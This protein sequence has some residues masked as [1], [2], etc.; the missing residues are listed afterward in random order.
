MT[1][2]QSAIKDIIAFSLGRQ[3][4]LGGIKFDAPDDTFD[5]QP[6]VALLPVS[7]LSPV[8]TLTAICTAHMTDSNKDIIVGLLANACCERLEQFIY[9]VEKFRFHLD[10]Y[11]ILCVFF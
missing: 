1:Q 11:I 8:E 5:S 7:L 2:V 9:Q 6:A 10:I 4:A 3:G